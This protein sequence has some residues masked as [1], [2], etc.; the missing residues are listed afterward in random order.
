ML[1][2]PDVANRFLAQTKLSIIV[3]SHEV[4]QEGCSWVSLGDGRALWTVFSASNYSGSDNKGAV[5]EFFAVDHQPKVHRYQSSAPLGNTEIDSQNLGKLEHYIGQRNHLLLQGFKKSDKNNSGRVSIGEW[6]YVMKT[7]LEMNID[8]NAI[9]PT[10]NGCEL[11]DPRDG[12][13]ATVCYKTFLKNYML[14]DLQQHDTKQAFSILQ[15]YDNF[16]MLKAVFQTWD[17]DHN[18]E[19][20]RDEF[21]EAIGLLN[22]EL[23]PQHQIDAQEIFPLIDIDNSGSI[24]LNEF[25]ESYRLVSK[26]VKHRKTGAKKRGSV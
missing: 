26:S 23:K 24:D 7:T 11:S 13:K 17:V 8:W 3:R 1:F 10:L 14:G 19:V 21:C 16:P 6:A 15:L 20:D 12:A 9:R 2:G 22:K 18:C 25:C 5:L 4:M